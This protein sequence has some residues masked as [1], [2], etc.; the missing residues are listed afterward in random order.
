MNAGEMGPTEIEVWARAE[1]ADGV[2]FANANGAFPVR[3][4]TAMDTVTTIRRLIAGDSLVVPPAEGFLADTMDTEIEI[5]AR[6]G[7]ELQPAVEQLLDYPYGCVEQTSSRMWALIEA[8]KLVKDRVED[9]SRYG[10][11]DDMISAGIARLWSMQ[12]RS[13]GLSYWPGSPTADRWGTAYACSILAEAS[14]VGFK[15]DAGFKRDLVQYIDKALGDSDLH[16]DNVRAMMCESL[17]AFDKPNAGWMARLSERTERLDLEGRASLARAWFMAGERERARS[18]LPRELTPV[19]VKRTTGGRL[20]SEVSQVASLVRTLKLIDPDSPWIVPLVETIRKAGKGGSWASTLENARA[21]AALAN[22]LREEP[23]EANY[24]GEIQ[25]DGETLTFD[26]SKPME[27]SERRVNKPVEIQTKGTGEM[28]VMCRQKG[29][30][31]AATLSDFDRG[32]RVRRKW[33]LSDGKPAKGHA[34][35]VGELV[36]V[37]ITLEATGLGHGEF[38]DNVAIVDALPAGFEIENPRL[39]TSAVSDEPMPQPDRVQFLDDRVLLFARAE[40]EPRTY[41]YHLRS[42]TAGS[43]VVPPVE[44]SCM[45]DGTLA[46]LQVGGGVEIEP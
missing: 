14:I 5:D 39:A 11:I 45:Y 43:F 35:R 33:T 40:G 36:T 34:F 46:S 32:L 24:T 15:I 1:S 31:D 3:P 26:Q 8:G 29:L 23:A 27:F 20:T 21:I 25:W 41:R 4:A 2:I 9:D 28:I 10:R 12:T 44:A 6:T 18:V 38:V 37:E 7:L 22:V 16:D 42:V 13:G 30:R 19:V 17:A